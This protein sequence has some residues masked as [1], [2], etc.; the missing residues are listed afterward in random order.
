MQDINNGL[1]LNGVPAFDSLMQKSFVDHYMFTVQH[2]KKTFTQ[3]YYSG[4]FIFIMVVLIVCIG[5]ILSYKQFKLNEEIIRHNMK[6]NNG[7]LG[8]VTDTASSME[9]SKDGIKMNTAVSR[10]DDIGNI[11]GVLFSLFKVCI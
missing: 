9:V 5:L 8:K 11:V 2:E 10:T 4:I 6:H 7:T 3:Q 1:T